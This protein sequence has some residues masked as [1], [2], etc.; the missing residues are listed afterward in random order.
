MSEYDLILDGSHTPEYDE[1]VEYINM[2]ARDLWRQING[3]IQQRYKSLPRIMYSVCS[4][5]PGWNVKYQKSGK[6]ICTLYPEQDGFVALVV[7]TL[8]L[9]PVI[10]ALS[11]ELTEETRQTIRSAKPFNGTKWLML[12]VK[13]DLQLEDVK[14]LISLK[15][16]AIAK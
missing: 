5:K 6:S 10:E 8:D 7:V 4:G 14:Q 15:Q 12:Q 2:P 9:M 1:I 11:G 16:G 13:N 3:F